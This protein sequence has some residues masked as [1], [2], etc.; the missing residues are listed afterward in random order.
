MRLFLSESAQIGKQVLFRSGREVSRRYA[1]SS[2]STSTSTPVVD[3]LRDS[4]S[5]VSASTGNRALQ[6]LG[7]GSRHRV[8]ARALSTLVGRPGG[9]DSVEV[10]DVAFER[11]R[12]LAGG[13]GDVSSRLL[14]L[15]A[16][17]PLAEV[18]IIQPN[19]SKPPL[20]VLPP[21]V[22]LIWADDSSGSP[23]TNTDYLSRVIKDHGITEF[24]PGWGNLSEDPIQLA[25]LQNVLGKRGRILGPNLSFISDVGHK[26]NA[27]VLAQKAGVPIVP[28]ADGLVTEANFTQMMSVFKAGI[29][30]MFKAPESGGGYGMRK[31]IVGRD[32]VA[33]HKEACREGKCEGLVAEQFLD[34]EFEHFEI[35]S[36]GV[37]FS[38]DVAPQ[39]FPLR[40]ERDC[41]VQWRNAKWVQLSNPAGLPEPVRDKMVNSSRNLGNLARQMGP[42]THEYLVITKPDTAQNRDYL[43]GKYRATDTDLITSD[44][45][46]Y[47][48]VYNETNPRLQVEH[49]VTEMA[50]R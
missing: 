45:K 28:G 11:P 23:F 1:S 6:F 43:M 5:S 14:R 39:T 32:D 36:F 7:S 48:V 25:V 42:A 10:S 2:A 27:R 24:F 30:I 47:L 49:P 44:G 31:A 13:C 3:A 8:G 33:M 34:D 40:L 50:Y 17:Q 37:Q 46:V 4:V 16:E 20:S 19:G 29:P 12:I 15:A 26:G 41:S 9:L 22:K 38:E 21:N 18:F 35:Q